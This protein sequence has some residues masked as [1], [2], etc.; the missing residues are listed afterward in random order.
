MKIGIMG[1]TFD[2]IHNGHLMLAEYAYR[3]YGLDEVWFLPNGNPPHKQNPA[4]Q[5]DTFERVEMTRLAISDV[6]YFKLC[7]Y[8]AENQNKS[9]TYRTLIHFREKYPQ[10]AFYYIIGADSL[11]DIETWA[12]PEILLGLAVILAAYR[13]DLDTPD[14]M[15]TRIQF[16]NEKYQAD[17]RLL[18]TP[19][20]DI[21][22]HEIREQIAK[23][24]NWQSQVP[25][26]VAS[27]IKTQGLYQGDDN[28]RRTE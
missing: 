13:D 7:T 28:G 12:H 8:E 25:L 10:H 5:K 3:N 2:P 27:Y 18:R 17:I 26:K 19:L 21:S 9:Y 16:L 6:P 22:S 14:E 11:C 4:I 24:E 20:M 23:D 15:N 1:G